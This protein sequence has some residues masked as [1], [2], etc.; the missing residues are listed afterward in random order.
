[1]DRKLMEYEPG[2]DPAWPGLAASVS[3][4]GSKNGR[5]VGSGLGP[6]ADL[7]SSNNCVNRNRVEF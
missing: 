4:V 7:D 1:M 6:P 5:V 2:L 3:Q